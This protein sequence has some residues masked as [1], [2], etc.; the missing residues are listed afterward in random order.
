M[1]KLYPDRETKQWFLKVIQ[2][3]AE[4]DLHTVYQIT[5]YHFNIPLT[6]KNLWRLLFIRSGLNIT[7]THQIWSYCEVKVKEWETIGSGQQQLK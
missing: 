2:S 4:N 1:N 3:L 7:L 6:H 5:A